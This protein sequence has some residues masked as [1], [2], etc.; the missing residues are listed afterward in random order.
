MLRL[1]EGS[2]LREPG[3]EKDLLDWEVTTISLNTRSVLRGESWSFWGAKL[4]VKWS[5][6]C[7]R[8]KLVMCASASV[9]KKKCFIILIS[10]GFCD[11]SHSG[12]HLEIRLVIV[13]GLFNNT[14]VT[15]AL[16]EHLE[17]QPRTLLLML[18]Y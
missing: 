7:E 16:F 9:F 8:K 3:R 6:F 14:T 4:L 17:L 2:A 15:G 13:W 11:L 10:L 1:R 5:E 12:K 18:F